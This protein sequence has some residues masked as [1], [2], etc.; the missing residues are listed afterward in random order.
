MAIVPAS[1]GTTKSPSG[2]TAAIVVP[3]GGVPAGALIVLA[4]TEE[5]VVATG[6][7]VTDA[8]GNT[9]LAG[10]T[11]NQSG[12]KITAAIFYTFNCRPL[13]T[14]QVITYTKIGHGLTYVSALYGTGATSSNPHDSA[15]DATA[16]GNS[17]SPSVT[18]GAPTAGGELFVAVLAQT[19]GAVGQIFSS[20]PSEV[21]TQDTADGW[22]SPPTRLLSNPSYQ[23]ITVGFLIFGYQITASGFLLAGGTALNSGSGALRYKPTSSLGQQ[24]AAAITAF[25]PAPTSAMPIDP[26]S[27][28]LVMLP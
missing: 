24:Y 20:P 21:F 14:G 4:V 17:T 1:L 18:S 19:M 10:P 6:G 27:T 3:S 11:I 2:T 22:A 26:N 23:Q 12:G 28:A 9:Y 25:S 8:A 13:N 16:S 7:S 5:G 15:A